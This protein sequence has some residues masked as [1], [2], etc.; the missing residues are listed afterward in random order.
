MMAII[1]RSDNMIMI[2]AIAMIMIERS[3]NNDY[4]H[5][6]SDNYGRAE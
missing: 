3:D 5:S 4:G 1:K 6:D 2:I